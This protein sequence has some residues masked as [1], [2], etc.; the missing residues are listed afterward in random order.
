MTENELAEVVI[1][2]CIKIH[3]RLGPG[4]LESVYESAL[5]YELEK[6]GIPYDR[7]KPI[8]VAYD[9]TTLDLGFRV[10]VIVAEKLL[11]ELKSTE[12]VTAIHHKILL[13]YLKLSKIKLGLL[14]N[15]RHIV[16]KDGIKRIANNL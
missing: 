9:D 16:L 14:I 15:F 7:Q 8:D 11:L 10:D 1:G 6:A 4:L 5:C 13:T 2:L 3:K 12:S